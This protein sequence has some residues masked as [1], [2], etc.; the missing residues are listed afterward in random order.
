MFC[1]STDM[2]IIC[3]L[4]LKINHYV[5]ASFVLYTLTSPIVS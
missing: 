2:F 3:P 1:V 4:M 5:Y